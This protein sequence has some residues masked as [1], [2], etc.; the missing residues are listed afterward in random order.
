MNFYRFNANDADGE[1]LI[2]LLN[3]VKV[4][5]GA[6][7]VLGVLHHLVRVEPSKKPEVHNRRLD[8]NLNGDV[9]L[10][11]ILPLGV[12]KWSFGLRPSRQDPAEDEGLAVAQTG[13]GELGEVEAVAVSHAG[14]AGRVEVAAQDGVQIGLGSAVKEQ[15]LCRI[16]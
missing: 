6:F 15:K 7:V 1:D 10:S 9:Q 2:A 3:D 5:T 8:S 13:H 11:L 4:A 14:D 16:L 12:E